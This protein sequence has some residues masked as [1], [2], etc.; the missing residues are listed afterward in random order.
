MTMQVMQQIEP[1]HSK[2]TMDQ[3]VQQLGRWRLVLPSILFLEATKPFSFFA[4]QGL[5]LCQPF[6]GFFGI[7]RQVSEYSE[8]LGERKNIDRLISQLEQEL[9]DQNMSDRGED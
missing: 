9:S 6:M 2:R 4:S 3:L 7:D 1:T 5:L 8:L